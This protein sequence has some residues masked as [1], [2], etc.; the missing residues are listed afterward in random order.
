MPGSVSAH[1]D[2]CLKEKSTIGTKQTRAE[3]VGSF[4]DLTQL[5]RDQRPQVAVSGRSNVGKSSLLN[6]LVGQR[7]LAKVSSTPGKTRALNFFLIDEKYYLVDLPGYG[8]AK[9][10]KSIKDEWGKLIEQYLNEEKR[11]AG[12]VFLLD[13]RRDPAEEDL[14][15]LSWLADRGL[16]VMLVITKAD[17]LGRDKLSQKMRQV[18]AELG[19]PSIAFSAVTGLG[20]EQ[21]TSAIR[22]LVASARKKVT[23]H[24]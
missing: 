4:H 8:Y 18:E 2:F 11:I 19:L 1:R 23:A 14:Q 13:C 20:K 10:S 9:V 12:M 6:K 22:Q 16:P 5:P 17:K 3:F 21:L 7:K 24:G 15:L